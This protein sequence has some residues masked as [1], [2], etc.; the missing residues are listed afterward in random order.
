MVGVA[1]GHIDGVQPVHPQGVELVHYLVPAL[2]GARVD[3]DP[4]P[5]G[6]GHQAGVPLAHGQEKEVHLV[7]LDGPLIELRRVRLG[8]WIA[9]TGQ[10]QQRQ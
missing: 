10:H 5:G 7:R 6:E 1:V 3:H 9:A 8:L 2:E 4:L